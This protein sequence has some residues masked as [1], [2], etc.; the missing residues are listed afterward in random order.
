MPSSTADRVLFNPDA[1]APAQRRSPDGLRAVRLWLAMTALLVVAI[2]LVGGATRLTDSGLSITEWKPVVGA[3]PPLSQADWQAEFMAYQH[4]PQYKL[5]NEGMSL[6]EFKVIYWWEWGHRQLGRLIGLV[7]LGGLV[8]FAARRVVNLRQGLM[9]FAA[10]LLLAAQGLVGWIM[11]ASGLAPG[12]TAVAP[13]KLTLHL[14]LACLFFAAL[15]ALIA[16]LGRD[17]GD[18]AS[19]GARIGAWAITIAI[20][21]QTA[22]GGLVAGH[23]A[24]LTYNTWPLMDGALVPDGLAALSPLWMNLV[25]NI[26]AIQFNHRIG[27][28]GLTLL[29]CLHTLFVWRGAAPAVRHRLAGLSVLVVGQMVL[30]IVTLVYVVP[31]IAA[32]AHQGLALIMLAVA[33][34]HAVRLRPATAAA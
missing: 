14:T 6:A 25:D 9:L 32:L 33:V 4:T 11:V 13:V 31:F 18:S 17:D 27:A 3:V 30:G 2:V 28:Y 8:W 26:M 24:G 7:F 5:L 12:M 1:M 20:F 15:V 22:L 21:L 34:W 23:D 19:T 16:R 10:G 29:I